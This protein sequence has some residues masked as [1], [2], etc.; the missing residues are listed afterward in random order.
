[1][2][3]FDQEIT[4]GLSNTGGE[5]VVEEEDLNDKEKREYVPPSPIPILQKMPVQMV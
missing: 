5:I 1:M 2:V 4:E 3:D